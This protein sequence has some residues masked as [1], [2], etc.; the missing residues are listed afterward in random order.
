MSALTCP[1]AH[2]KIVS[3]VQINMS[4][5]TDGGTV[6]ADAR[7]NV[8]ITGAAAGIGA[9]VTRRLVSDGYT[10]YAGVHSDAGSLDRRPPGLDRRDRSG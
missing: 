5:Q 4:L 1:D 3:P 8:F 2:A 9:A 7:G 6:S 10:V